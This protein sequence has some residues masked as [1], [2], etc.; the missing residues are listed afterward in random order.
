M[1]C[2][3][4]YKN[5]LVSLQ[6]HFQFKILITLD[7]CACSVE[8]YETFTLY[9]FTEKLPKRLWIQT[10]TP[11]FGNCF[12]FNSAFNDADA[13][14]SRISTVTGATSGDSNFHWT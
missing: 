1:S 12:T 7:M 6:R 10:A 5:P 2:N 13:D 8:P 11:N 4:I 9:F 14:T 3:T